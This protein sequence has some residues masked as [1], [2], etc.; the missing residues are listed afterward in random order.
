MT[1]TI[2]PRQLAGVAEIVAATGE[3]K[4][5]VSMWITRAETNGFPAPVAALA[6]GRVWDISD[7][8]AWY[9]TYEPS[10]GARNAVSKA[11]GA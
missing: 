3:A 4:S 7:V 9:L 11:V 6:A 8:L 1:M 5:T 2:D 10:N